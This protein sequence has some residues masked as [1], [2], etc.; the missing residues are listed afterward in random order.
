[1]ARTLFLSLPVLCVHQTNDIIAKCKKRRKYGDIREAVRVRG[2]GGRGMGRRE[3]H[4]MLLR[5]YILWFFFLFRLFI[6]IALLSVRVCV[7][8]I[9][10]KAFMFVWRTSFFAALRCS[11]LLCS[12]LLL[13]S[14]H[15]MSAR[16]SETLCQRDVDVY[17]VCTIWT[18]A[19][20]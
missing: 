14:C 4:Q 12:A 5:A 10:I 19:A 1:M 15:A 6:I 9:S 7:S 17:I 13:L 3:A 18:A 11:A 2:R 16:A 8:F 20:Q